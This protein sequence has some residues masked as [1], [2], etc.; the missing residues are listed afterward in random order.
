MDLGLEGWS[1]SLSFEFRSLISFG[2][3]IQE[4]GVDGGT[5]MKSRVLG[6]SPT[7]NNLK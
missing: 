4:I 1:I 5:R 2:L 7:Q 3:F 6:N